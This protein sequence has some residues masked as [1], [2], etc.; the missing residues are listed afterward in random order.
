M[1]KELVKLANHLDSKGLVK[2]ADYID[3]LVKNAGLWDSFKR[4]FKELVGISNASDCAK[5]CAGAMLMLGESA[6]NNN[7]DKC[8]R[9]GYE[10]GASINEKIGIL[11]TL[12]ELE[13]RS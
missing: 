2:E 5:K 13:N 4:T 3:N 6:R 7:P 11:N 9:T 8:V 12:I 10:Y 1:L